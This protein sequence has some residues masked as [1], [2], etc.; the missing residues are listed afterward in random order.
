M[1]FCAYISKHIDYQSICYQEAD[2]CHFG[3]YTKRTVNENK[4]TPFGRSGGVAGWEARTG[5]GLRQR[6]RRRYAPE[7]RP[8]A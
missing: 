7:S 8:A 6:A 1:L 5:G 2:Q 4:S 3:S